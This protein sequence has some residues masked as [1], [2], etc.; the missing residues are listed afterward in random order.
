[1]VFEDVAI[2][3]SQEEWNLLDEAQRLLYHQVMLENFVLLTSLG[4][5]HGAQEGEAPLERGDCAGVPQVRTPKAGA[6]TEEAQPYDTSGPLRTDILQGAE[7]DGTQRAEG[8]HT[9]GAHPRQHRKE[10]SRWSPS[11]MAGRRV[12]MAE[13]GWTCGEGGGALQAFCRPWPPAVW[14][15]HRGT[16]TVAR[17][18]KVGKVVTCAASVGIPAARD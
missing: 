18:L 1:M 12:C 5:P 14:G 10:Q 16:W 11:L 8:P 3:F 4:S 6:S 9:R 7:H 13:R 15:S 2:Q 17:P